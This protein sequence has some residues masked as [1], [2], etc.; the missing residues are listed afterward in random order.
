MIV[1]GKFMNSPGLIPRSIHQGLG[2]RFPCN[3]RTDEVVYNE[4]I[5]NF[6]DTSIRD[7]S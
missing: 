3:D 6:P 4:D 1:M 5:I 2:L 7:Q